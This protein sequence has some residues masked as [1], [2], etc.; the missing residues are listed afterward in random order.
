MATHE[1]IELE[2]AGWQ[3]LS[4]DGPTATSFYQRVLDESVLMLLPNG[5][6]LT[7]R[8]TIIEAMSGQP[9]ASFRMDSPQVLQ[10][11]SDT[12]IVA[13]GIDAQREGDS[14]Y[15]ALVSSHY[16]RRHDG[17]RLTFHQ[18]THR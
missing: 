17:W 16:V 9:W 14:P 10:P 4:S 3:A 2:T 13:Y 5:I 18:Q 8:T 1:L 7:D 12:G 6:M 11:T 15:S